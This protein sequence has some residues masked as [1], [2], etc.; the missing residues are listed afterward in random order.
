MK[1]FKFELKA[2]ITNTISGESGIV[3]GRSDSIDES[4]GYRVEHIQH[5]SGRMVSSFWYERQVKLTPVV[6]AVV[7]KKAAPTPAVKKREIK[8][9]ALQP[10]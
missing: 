1:K 9:P 7:K 3:I 4:N 6:K 10:A 2:K 8:S 5:G